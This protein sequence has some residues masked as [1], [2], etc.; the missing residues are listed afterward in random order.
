MHDPASSEEPWRPTRQVAYAHSVD[1]APLDQWEPLVDHLKRVAELAA[2]FA[3]EFDS[4]EWGW[5]AGLWHD[6][7]KYRRDFQDRI[8]GMRVQ[9]PHASAGAAYAV[10]YRLSPIAFAIA[11]HHAGLANRVESSDGGPL[12][13]RVALEDG[14]G[15]LDEIRAILPSELTDVP[16]PTLPVHLRE[17]G[18][19]HPAIKCAT[20]LWIRMLFS[21]LVDADRLATEAFYEP[22]KRN[23]L[24]G[25]DCLTRVAERL[26]AYVDRFRADTP[27]NVLRARVL[28]DCRAAGAWE[29][30][31]FSLTVPTGGGKT[32]SSMAFALAHA[33]RHDLRRV[34]VVAPFTSIIEQ[35][36][37][38]YREALG[39][40]NVVEQH[41]AVEDPVDGRSSVNAIRRRLAAENW[42]APVVVTTAVQF[43]E[44]LLSNDASRCRKL[45]NVVGTVIVVDEAQTIPTDF[46]VCLLDVL[47][48]L[49]RGYGCSVVLSTATQPALRRRAGFEYGIENMREIISA[50][51]ELA[52]ALRRVAIDWPA[53]GAAPIPFADLAATI[54]RHPRVLAVVHLTADARTLAEQLP[55]DSRYHLS[56]RMCAAHRAQVLRGIREALKCGSTCRVVSTQLIEAGVDVDFPV[57]FRA[58]AGLDSVAQA[59]GRCNRNG[60]LVD[61]AGDAT[62]GRVVVFRAETNPPPG[63]LRKGLAAADEMLAARGDALDIADASTLEEYFRRLYLA[64]PHDPRG[65]MLQRE[66][67]NFANVERLVRLIDDGGRCPLV[68][69]WGDGAR[70]RHDFVVRPGRE[71][72]RALQRFVVQVRTQDLRQ[73]EALGAA[74]VVDG[75]GYELTPAYAHLYHPEFGLLVTDDA[76]ADPAALMV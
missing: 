14:K 56:T 70:R 40:K 73:L 9:A 20:E 8:R 62:L 41:S 5:L 21:A 4:A 43:F 6:L 30:G 3:R 69:P 19:H 72:A 74:S 34:I 25:F 28:T 35:N 32:L 16:P 31:F 71:T 33:R 60:L 10:E 23:V 38:V 61:D 59:A 42:D 64:M 45:H 63:V 17:L 57:V 58:M 36:A 52:Q 55:P 7:G 22:G 54:A 24:D 65:V 2:R 67:L 53:P 13:L 15:V 39:E 50:P 51:D 68:V 66:A 47:R 29:R 11:G 27:V 37:D 1:G 46:L 76:A 49:V 18:S 26:D 48:E 75:F 12:P 44:S